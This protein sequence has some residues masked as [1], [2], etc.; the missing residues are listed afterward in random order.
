MR[1]IAARLAALLCLATACAMPEKQSFEAQQRIQTVQAFRAARDTGEEATWRPYLAPDPRIWRGEKEGAGTP[2][3]FIAGRW[4]DWD[5]HFRGK[6]ERVSSW[7]TKGNRVWAEM[8]EVNDY[9]RLIER[10]GSYWRATYYLDDQ[11]RIAGFQ[12][13]P[14]PGREAP[15]GRGEEFRAWAR[16]EHPEE[17]EY[18]MPG[19]EIDPTGD[20][21]PRMRKLLNE[22][23]GTVGLD[24]IE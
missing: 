14:V 19:G 5:T 17:A 20:R 18:L 16:A 4:K 3:T 12:I 10:G 8:F 2:W 22:W 24:T 21:A 11:E 9:F 7:E 6:S 13:S 1:P 15:E 23:R